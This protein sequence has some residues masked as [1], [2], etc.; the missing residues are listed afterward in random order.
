MYT[1]TGIYAWAQWVPNQNLPLAL[2]KIKLIIVLFLNP[3][4]VL[5]LVQHANFCYYW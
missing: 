4:C 2:A 3:S 1:G 5:K